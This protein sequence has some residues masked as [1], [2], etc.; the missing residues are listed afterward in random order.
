MEALPP[1]LLFPILKWAPK[2]LFNGTIALVC[3]Q[4]CDVVRSRSMQHFLV[5][6]RFY[7]YE[8]K[9]ILPKTLGNHAYRVLAVKW[10]GRIYSA[11]IDKTIRVWSGTDGTLM[12]TLDGHICDVTTLAV[13]QDGRIY[14]GSTDRT[15]RV[16]CDADGTHLHTLEGHTSMILS[17]AVGNLFGVVR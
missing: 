8:K 16:W 11:S 5:R 12:Q 13:G 4:W 3:W 1:E 10:D 17:L 6:N 15:I 9:W 14:S 7:A 2:E